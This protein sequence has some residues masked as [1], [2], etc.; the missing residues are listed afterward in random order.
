MNQPPIPLRRLGRRRKRRR[1]HQLPLLRH[2][3]P[4]LLALL[5]LAIELLCDR[6]RP[7]H[8]AQLQHLD[9]ELPTLVLDAQHVSQAHLACRLGRL[10]IRGNPVQVARLRSLLPCFE[11]PRRPQPLI[12]PSPSHP[13]ILSRPLL[14]EKY[15]YLTPPPSRI[16][17]PKPALPKSPQ[18]GALRFGL[19]PPVS[20]TLGTL[21]RRRGRV[22]L[23]S[24][25]PAGSTCHSRSQNIKSEPGVR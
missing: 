14:R 11:K 17:L 12:D 4:R 19:I 20:K 18:T 16:P 7:Q 10:P 23:Q 2:L 9:L 1:P 5:G 22:H 15:P 3:L 6:R 13:S 24:P 8:V 21:A 25:K